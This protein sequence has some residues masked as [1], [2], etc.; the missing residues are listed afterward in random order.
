MSSPPTICRSNGSRDDE[1][2]KR[3]N[4]SIADADRPFL[5][6]A[7]I[8]VTISPIAGRGAVRPRPSNNRSKISTP[9]ST[10]PTR[11]V[12][13]AAS[14]V[15][16][17]PSSTTAFGQSR[18]GVINWNG[19]PTARPRTPRSAHRLSGNHLERLLRRRLLRYP[20]PA[21]SRPSPGPRST[22]ASTTPTCSK[23]T[24][25][26]PQRGRRRSRR[27]TPPPNCCASRQ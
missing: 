25:A 21:E 19:R 16:A 7:L 20:G 23:L 11:P 15:G 14:L 17:A 4:G 5:T 6:P 1:G 18:A 26:R 3:S 8:D 22:R 12:S 27:L 10:R 24:A 9:P 2:G 13:H